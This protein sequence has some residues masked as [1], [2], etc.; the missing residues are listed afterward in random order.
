[1]KQVRAE[2]EEASSE[3][4]SPRQEQELLQLESQRRRA[5]KLQKELTELTAE[6][7]V[8]EKA[9]AIAQELKDRCPTCRQS[10]PAAARVKETERLRERLSDLEGLLQGAREKLN[11]LGDLEAATERLEA[12]RGAVG[13][14]AKLLEEQAKVQAV[15]KPDAADLESRMTI[16]AERINKGERVLERAQQYQSARESWEAHVKEKS[17]LETRVVVLD[18]V[19]E[20]LGPHGAMMAQA[21]GWIGSFIK[22]LNTHLAAFGYACNFA[23]DPFEIRVISSA[24]NDPGLCL[25]HL[26]ESERFR[27]SIA[28]QLAVASATDIRFVVIDPADVLDK[29][30]RKL[31]TA[32]LLSSNI[33]QAIVLATG[34]DAPPHLPEGVKFMSLIEQ[35]PSTQLL[36]SAIA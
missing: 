11:E 8:V 22:N 15:R 17:E 23:L 27:F 14:R 29:Q 19:V 36:P 34:E 33:E 35:K 30:K 31:L 21:C 2:I 6:Q 13:R 5:D 18:R 7:R 12:H 32:L 10:I 9:L 4:L 20:F 1:V 24:G 28:I 25:R 16:L 3:I 26:S